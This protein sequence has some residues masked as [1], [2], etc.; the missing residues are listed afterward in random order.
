[1]NLDPTRYSMQNTEEIKRSS[2]G[3]SSELPDCRRQA[4]QG[5]FCAAPGTLQSLRLLL[6][7]RDRIER[8]PVS[9]V[10]R[11]TCAGR[12]NGTLVSHSH[13]NKPSDIIHGFANVVVAGILELFFQCLLENDCTRPAK[14]ARRLCSSTGP[15]SAAPA[16]KT[17]RPNDVFMMRVL[18]TQIC[19][20]GAGRTGNWRTISDLFA[21]NV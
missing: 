3:R 10:R 6:C 19:V 7:P 2:P 12:E 5:V 20:C 4:G 9:N 15:H 14:N 8:E 18:C 13:G 16:P 21:R 17:A 11:M 1:M